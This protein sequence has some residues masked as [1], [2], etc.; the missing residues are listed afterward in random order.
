MDQDNKFGGID[1]N[2]G[3]LMAREQM[4]VSTKIAFMNRLLNML[5][6]PTI[7]IINQLNKDTISIDNLSMIMSVYNSIRIDVD[8][9]N[10][11]I[12]EHNANTDI[13]QQCYDVNKFFMISSAPVHDRKTDEICVLISLYKKAETNVL[14]FLDDI[15][16]TNPELIAYLYMKELVSISLKNYKNKFA[17]ANRA[18][19]E[20]FRRNPNMDTSMRDE[21]AVAFA[22]MAMEFHV[23]SMLIDNFKSGYSMD[24]L[25]KD[26]LEYIHNNSFILYDSDY[27][28]KMSH[29]DIIDELMKDANIQYCD[30]K[31]TQNILSNNNDNKFKGNN[32]NS[33]DDEDDEDDD[34]NSTNISR[35]SSYTNRNDNDNDNDNQS[36]DELNDEG[37]GDGT[38]SISQPVTDDE[39]KF[40]KI[41]FNKNKNQIFFMKM[42]PKKRHN[43]YD[44]L[45]SLDERHIDRIQDH[46]DYS[47][48]KIKGTG[49]RDLF[50]GIGLP[51]SID[52]EWEKELI[53]HVDNMTSNILGDTTQA[54]WIKPNIYTRHIAYLPGRIKVPQAVPVIYVLFDQSGSMSNNIIRKINYVIEYFYKKKY[55]LNVLI[56]DDSSDADDVTVCEF[57]P[58]LHGA[59]SD[60]MR[61]DELVSS[62]IRCGG[63]SHK[64][65]FDLMER[66]IEDVTSSSKK[67]NV[68]YVLVCSDLYS[69]IEQI[70]Q[71]YKWPRLLND[72]NIYALC[73]EPDM[74]LPFGKTI[75]VS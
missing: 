39:N 64:G 57:R 32:G 55:D 69:D 6:N 26:K 1:N 48:S 7:N 24:P 35:S 25:L 71:N 2:T 54:T 74:K 72:S 66:Y 49:V 19:M 50:E 12:L 29:I 9:F 67:Y 40:L 27:N 43:R 46:I 10:L 21:A 70:W 20:L 47:V 14:D 37:T 58:S 45:D 61:L 23:N 30:G 17:L 44:D 75:Y 38:D 11:T 33:G 13:L 31:N 62:R 5:L 16:K 68:Q 73:P 4:S 3:M 65:V 51:I 42:P 34:P 52:M 28:Y 15:K 56:H 60:E 59:Y 53:R 8:I 41:T 22:K 18:R 36:D 63:T